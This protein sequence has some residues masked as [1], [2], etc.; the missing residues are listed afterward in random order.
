MEAQIRRLQCLLED[1]AR[2]HDRA[3][4]SLELDRRPIIL[5]EYLPPLM[6]AWRE[7]ALQKGLR[8]QSIIPGALPVIS[9]DPDRLAQALGNLVSNAITYTPPKGTVTINAGTAEDQVWIR[10]SDTGPG[11]AP[12]EQERIFTSFYR[13]QA[14]GRFA[15]GMGLGL[16]IARD[17]VTAH[18]GRLT[19]ESILGTGSHF[20]IW[21][22]Q[23]PS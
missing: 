17:L 22:P 5:S 2:L 21:L 16:T 13:G 12:E 4:G 19:V 9:A 1:L 8:W 6:S 20:T 15:Q 7:T 10:V 23:Q 3:V 11:I 14:G 18:G